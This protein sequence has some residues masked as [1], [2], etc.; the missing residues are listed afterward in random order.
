[1]HRLAHG[2]H[3]RAQDEQQLLEQ[4]FSRSSFCAVRCYLPVWAEVTFPKHQ[5]DDRHT[6]PMR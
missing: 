2:Q 3:T 6:I 5:F 4:H 1:M